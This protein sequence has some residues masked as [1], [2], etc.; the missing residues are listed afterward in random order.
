MEIFNDIL[1]GINIE[2]TAN[3]EVKPTRVAHIANM[4]YDKLSRYLEELK[5]KQL[6]VNSPIILT[7]KGRKFLQD[8]E[9]IHDFIT[10]M[11]LDYLGGWVRVHD[12]SVFRYF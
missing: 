8:Y 12:F 6:I 10:K 1:S 11:K 9:K 4:S 3:S 5:D 7:E 2:S